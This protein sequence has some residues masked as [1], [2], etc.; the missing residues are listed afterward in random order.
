MSKLGKSLVLLSEEA[1]LI[2]NRALKN[3][4]PVWSDFISWQTKCKDVI[5]L[6]YG[7]SSR[8]L[9]EFNG[10]SYVPPSSSATEVQHLIAFILGVMTAQQRLKGFLFTVENFIDESEKIKTGIYPTIFLSRSKKAEKLSEKLKLFLSNLGATVIDV[11]K[12]P[13]LNLST[14]NKIAF[15]MKPCNCGIILVSADEILKSGEKRERPNI[16]H[17]MGL[18]E[19]DQNIAGRIIILKE[20]SLILPSNFSEKSYIGFNRSNFSDVFIDLVKELRGFGFY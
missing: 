8:N 4:H 11:I 1:T 12:L 18:L 5:D 19:K 20:E 7:P 6:I 14:S 17:E 2:I 10:I 13:N 16:D 9:A 3:K 15:Y